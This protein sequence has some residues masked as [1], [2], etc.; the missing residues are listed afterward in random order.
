MLFAE[1]FKGNMSDPAERAIRS[2]AQSISCSVEILRGGALAN[3]AGF[4]DSSDIESK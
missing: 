2:A 3:R 4:L 1:T